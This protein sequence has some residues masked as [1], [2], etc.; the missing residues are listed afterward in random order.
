MPEPVHGII[1]NAYND[2]LIPLFL[3]LVPLGL[4]STL[5]LFFIR[6]DALATTLDTE[7]AVDIAR[8][9]TGAMPV[10]TPEMA[11]K[12]A[13]ALKSMQGPNRRTIAE[14]LSSDASEESVAGSKD[15]SVRG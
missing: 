13:Q 2:A 10:I 3:Y 6:E 11:A 5:L 9:A 1:V 4:V 15:L 8:A 14:S 7:P 12:D